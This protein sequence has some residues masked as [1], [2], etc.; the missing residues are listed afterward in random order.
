MNRK[1]GKMASVSLATVVIAAIAGGCSNNKAHEAP[2]PATTPAATPPAKP[3]AAPATSSARALA[4]APATTAATNQPVKVINTMC[5]IGGDEF[6]SEP[7]PASL[8]RQWKGKEIGFCCKNCVAKF[9][10]MTDAQRDAV[11]KLAEA[12]RTQ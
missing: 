8:S 5:P 11:L 9:D 1:M 4:A 6:G 10:K 2:A 3:A 12:N 7:H